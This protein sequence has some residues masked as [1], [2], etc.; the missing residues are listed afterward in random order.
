MDAETSFGGW[1]K[2]RRRALDLTQAELAC[3]ASCTSESIR[4]LEAGRQRPSKPLA[5]RLAEALALPS[6]ERAGFVALARAEPS[7]RRPDLLALLE[8]DA[9]RRLELGDRGAQ[10]ASE[11]V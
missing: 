11:L 7:S 8:R 10:V 1:L 5:A 3:R 4:K 9:H 6:E 2:R